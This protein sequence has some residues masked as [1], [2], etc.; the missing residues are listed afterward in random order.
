FPSSAPLGTDRVAVRL[1]DTGELLAGTNVVVSA[2]SPG[3]FAFNSSGQ[4]AAINQDGGINSA[5]NP[6]L[7]GSVISLYGTG[8]G[9]VSPPA[10][11]GIGAPISPLSNTIAV[12]TSDGKTCTASQP[13]MC[14]AIGNGFGDIMYSGLAP[15]GV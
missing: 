1:S 11:D 5:S 8:L 9:P 13:S 7:R 14:V 12:P 6:A 2:A 3:L 4:A 15:G 10:P